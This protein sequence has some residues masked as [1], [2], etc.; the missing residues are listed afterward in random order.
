MAF[1]PRDMQELIDGLTSQIKKVQ[2]ARTRLKL[3]RR[4][5][6]RRKE[7]KPVAVERRVAER[8]SGVEDRRAVRYSLAERQQ[9]EK[10]L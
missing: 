5:D 4:E 7:V 1:F 6:T 10:D 2:E 8:R 3:E 9:L